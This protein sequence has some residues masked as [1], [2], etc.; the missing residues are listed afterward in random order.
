M[1]GLDQSLLTN[2]LN[3]GQLVPVVQRNIQL[4][5]VKL[6]NAVQSRSIDSPFGLIRQRNVI[7]KVTMSSCSG[8][9]VS[10]QYADNF[11][12]CTLGCKSVLWGGGRTPYMVPMVTIQGVADVANIPRHCS[13]LY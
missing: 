9:K 1:F 10:A 2:H 8:C 4:Q 5:V 13:V 6:L 7:T 12:A 3:L 11:D